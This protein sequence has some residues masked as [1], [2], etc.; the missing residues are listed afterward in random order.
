MASGSFLFDDLATFLRLGDLIGAEHPLGDQNLGEAPLRRHNFVSTLYPAATQIR[1]EDGP[2]ARRSAAHANC[3]FA[4]SSP[5][6][7]QLPIAC[8]LREIPTC[9]RYRTARRAPAIWEV[10]ERGRSPPGSAEKAVTL[11]KFYSNGVLVACQPAG[12]GSSTAGVP[13]T[14]LAANMHNDPPNRVDRCAVGVPGDRVSLDK[15]ALFRPIIRPT[16]YR[17][18]GGGGR[19]A[20][21][22]WRVIRAFR[23]GNCSYRLFKAAVCRQVLVNAPSSCRHARSDA[24]LPPAAVLAA[25]LVLGSSPRQRR[26]R[27]DERGD[28]VVGQCSADQRAKDQRAGANG[29]LRTRDRRHNGRDVGGFGSERTGVGRRG[30]RR[31][32]KP[33]ACNRSSRGRSDLGPAAIKSR[34]A[35]CNSCPRPSRSI[36]R[37]G[38]ALPT[39]STD[40][41]AATQRTT[42]P[43]MDQSL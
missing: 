30:L 26:K 31:T 21:C 27:P 3:L 34:P 2:K 13:A 29:S 19:R 16:F 24:Y 36:R 15:F 38:P 41:L 22:G 10:G 17:H 35:S 12:G 42:G 25:W 28:R 4:C 37:W 9:R 14:R 8:A 32:R 11:F 5:A 43:P 33:T 7:A 39:D 1:S 18:S 23:G 20:S 40:R 6:A